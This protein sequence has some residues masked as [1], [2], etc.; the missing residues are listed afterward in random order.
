MP[1]EKGVG[2]KLVGGTLD[3][4]AATEV[5]KNLYVERATAQLLISQRSE[6]RTFWFD[7]GQL[8]G[9]AS[10]R[11]AQLVGELLRTFGLADEAVLFAAF[12]RALAEPGRGLA[13]AL[14][15]TGAVQAFVA[16]ACVRALAERIL[17]DTFQWTSG[18]YTITPLEKAPNLP[19]RFDR[20]NGSLILE[21]LRRLPFDAPQAGGHVDPRS[22]PTLSSD[23]LLRYQYL[24]LSAEEAD[25]LSRID[26]ERPA[27]EVTADLRIL[28]R[29]AAIGLIQFVPSGKTTEKKEGPTGLGSLNVEVSNAAPP[30]RAAELLQTQTAT[31]WN[32]Y[33]RMDWVTLYEI[34]G[35]T[36]ESVPEDLQRALFDRARMFHPDNNLKAG[37]NDAR[38]ALESLFRKVQMAY[39]TFRS[40]ENREAYDIAQ[41][42]GGQTVAVQESKP[43]IEV[44]R[45]IARANY[46][47]ARTLFEQEDYYPAYEMVKQSVEFDPDKPEYWTMLSRVQRKNPK[48]VRQAA[49]TMRRATARFPENPELWFELSEACQAER[50]E[51]E[52]VKALKEVLKLDPGNRR[53][54]QALAEIASMKPGR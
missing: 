9:A 24:F 23:L 31:I 33:R 20:S 50:N 48:W 3:R 53:A 4:T 47:R 8:I 34:V 18:A 15:E 6:E 43:E 2:V 52:R 46:M 7:R 17:Y 5:F 41:D 22:K 54:Q 37:L 32:T 44:R 25:A 27:A 21:A 39:T 10:N 29:L 19:V 26:A 45:Q 11:E 13:K 42:R 28:N 30:A 16:D 40:P 12:E 38:E 51:T 35:A 14:S 49:E 1:A 36:R